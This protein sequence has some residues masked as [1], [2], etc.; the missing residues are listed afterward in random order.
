VPSAYSGRSAAYE[1]LGEYEKA[2]ADLDTLVQLLEQDIT[3]RKE[4]KDPALG[5]LLREAA[6]AHE[7]RATFLIARKQSGEAKAK[8]STDQALA[9]LRRAV[10]LLAEAAAHE[11]TK[12][13]S[14]PDFRKQDNE[15]KGMSK[16]PKDPPVETGWVR[17]VNDWANEIRVDLSDAVYHLKPGQERIILRKAG[18]FTFQIR[19]NKQMSDITQVES[20]NP[21]RDWTHTIRVYPKG[22][23]TTHADSAGRPETVR[24]QPP[25]TR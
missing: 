25:H 12:T 21:Q 20:R 8:E 14:A 5:D 17:I 24:G 7:R 22:M 19:D 13:A 18:A 11:K 15:G 4:L 23:S 1:A 16:T 2:Q 10:G 3:S 9:D 6:V